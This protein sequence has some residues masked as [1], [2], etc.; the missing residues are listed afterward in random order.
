[1]DDLRKEK[2]SYVGNNKWE[3]IRFCVSY[4]SSSQLLQTKI[5]EN[6][7]AYVAESMYVT[8]TYAQ[9]QAIAHSFIHFHFLCMNIQKSISTQLH[10]HYIIITIQWLL[11]WWWACCFSL[12]FPNRHNFLF[13]PECYSSELASYQQGIL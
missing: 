9:L 8:Q 13:S 10:I 3:H 7:Y 5:M 6:H 1:M 11:W 4:L 12:L 2:E